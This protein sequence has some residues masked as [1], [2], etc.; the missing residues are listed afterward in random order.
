MKGSFPLHHAGCNSAGDCSPP[1]GKGHQRRAKPAER[2][3]P[4]LPCTP[5]KGQAPAV[6]PMRKIRK[7]RDRC[8]RSY[9]SRDEYHSVGGHRRQPGRRAR[10]GLSGYA[11]QSPE[12]QCPLPRS[13]GTGPRRGHPD[14]G[15]IAFGLPEKCPHDNGQEIRKVSGTLA[16]M[17]MRRNPPDTDIPGT[18]AQREIVLGD[19]P[20]HGGA[21]PPC[22]GLQG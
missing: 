3:E 14:G 22:S 20:C 2:N 7:R 15:D 10:N 6:Q 11:V 8:T 18:N 4:G 13:P 17:R 5:A 19:E 21:I 1:G 9:G 12:E 16:E